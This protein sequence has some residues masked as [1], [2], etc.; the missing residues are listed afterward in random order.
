MKAVRYHSYGGSDVL[1]HEEVDR[2]VAGVGQVVV[3]VAG[4]SFNDADAGL[5]A[6]LRQDL[7]PLALPHIPNLDLAGVI[8]EVGAG[9][10]GWRVGD[11]VVALL[12]PTVPG[13]A[14]EYVAAPAEALA[15]APRTV[16]LADAGALPLVGLTA[17][18]SLF[19]H[20]DLKPGQR[21]LINGA[22]SAVGGYAVQL[23]VRAGVTVTATAGACSR[24]RVRSYG[25]DRVVD[26]TATPVPRALAGQRFDVVLNLAPTSPEENV[27]LVDLVAEGGAFVSVTTPGP[28][29]AGRGVRT[30]RMFVR[31]DA[32]QLAE[33]VALVDAGDLAVEVAERLPLADLARVHA[34]AAARFAHIAELAARIEGGDL[35]ERLRADPAAVHGRTDAEPLAGKTVLIP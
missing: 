28:E 35:A 24:D 27:E 30:V 21:V 12:P 5:R 19:E 33:L 9:V 13:A 2:P 4:T 6:G 16:E 7:V 25:A 1:V 8:T 22:G 29:D 31:G 26:Y 23:A 20:A 14:A 32:A 3:R 34:R 17:W 15:T 10:T 11:A 18:Q